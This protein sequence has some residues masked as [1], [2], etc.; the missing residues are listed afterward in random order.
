MASS[1]QTYTSKF[2]EPDVQVV[3]EQN[4]AVFEPDAMTEALEAMRN[5][6]GNIVH[7]YDSIN[8]QE[9]LRDETP[10]VSD[11]NE[12]FNEQQPSH[13]DPT[14][15]NKHSSRT[16]TYHNQPS[17]ISDDEQRQSV[18][19]LNPGQRCAYDMVLSL[20]RQLIK[21]LNSL[22]PV[23]VKPIYLFLTESGGAGKSHLIKTIYHTAVKTFRRPPF[24]HE[25]PHVLLLAPTG[26]AM[27][28]IDGTTVN[29]GLAIQKKLVITFVEC[30]T[31][32]KHST[33]SL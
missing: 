1:D 33:G 27:I 32:R 23:D 5:N 17:E 7:S 20:C 25:L 26:V 18:R 9:N 19:S 3:V 22:K 14:H 2:Y 21:N 24:N 12:S 30:L 13:L 15:S 4:R 16:I 6:E 8:D 11:L 28:N 31:R 29:T 10:N